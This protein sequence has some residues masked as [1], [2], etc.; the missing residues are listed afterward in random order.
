MI[1]K[2]LIGQSLT[3]AALLCALSGCA[4]QAGEGNEDVAT[5][6]AELTASSSADRAQLALR[7]APVH[8]ED[9]DQTGSHALG[10]K[11]DYITRYD[12]DGDLDTQN[13]W[14][15]AGNSAY[16]LAAH[17]YYSVTETSSHWF[18]VYLFFHPRD[19]SDSFFDTEHEN[20][21]EG[22]LFTVR[23]DGSQFGVLQ[24]AITVAHKDFYSYVPAGSSWTSGHE[25]IDGTLPM[26]A[27]NG[28]LHPVTAQE[29]K[30]HGLKAR[31]GY[32]IVGDGVVYYPSLTTAEVPSDPNDRDV[33]YKL[34]DMLEPG[35]M[36]DQ[37]F[38]PAVFAGFGSFAG[39]QSG[40]CGA[41]TIGCDKNAANTP[42]GWNDQ[43][44]APAG[45]TL[46]T[47]PAGVV[48]DYFHIPEPIS[49]VY[50][51]NPYNAPLSD[52]QLYD[53]RPSHATN[54]CAD[55]EGGSTADGAN[56]S[57]YDCHGRGNQ[58]FW[59]FAQ[60]GGYFALVNAQSGK[61]LDQVPGNG[62]GLNVLQWACHFGD[63]QLWRPEQ[64]TGN[65]F[66]LVNKQSGRVLEVA[67]NQSTQNGANVQTWAYDGSGD[68]IWQFNRK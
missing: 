35:G 60:G 4:V 64:V 44:D 1:S 27:F 50:T 65:W 51:Y 53:L 43:D 6:S 10:G 58:L 54:K 48:Y 22:V 19:W 26:V 67:G 49:G 47:D 28:A 32:D 68:M 5:T 7:W 38:N 3:G 42:W 61:C 66:K 40:G 16:P 23:R 24:S 30:G 57:L 56:V 8:Y 31:G 52:N 62:D 17:A 20:D 9:V 45:G 55:V 29:A 21:A 33:S 18:I 14:D 36:W 34:V 11:A 37:R 12:Y 63:N 46:A 13:N 25:S 59:A 41:G 2:K 15:N 39:N